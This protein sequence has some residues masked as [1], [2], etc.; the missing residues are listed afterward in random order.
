MTKH[1]DAKSGVSFSCDGCSETYGEES[2]EDGDRADGRD[3]WQAAREEGWR[4]FKVREEWRH[5][6]P[7]CAEEI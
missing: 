7:S 5:A 1:R 3:V 6:C 2:M 4:A